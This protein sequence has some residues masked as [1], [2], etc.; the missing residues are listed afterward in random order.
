MVDIKFIKKRWSSQTISYSNSI[1]STGEKWNEIKK[2][3]KGKIDSLTFLS[4]IYMKLGFNLE[5]Y[6]HKSLSNFYYAN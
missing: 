2:I 3:E 1:I 5:E 4:T 6:Y